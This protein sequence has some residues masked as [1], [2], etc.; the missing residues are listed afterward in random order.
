MPAA[1]TGLSG[2]ASRRC[3]LTRIPGVSGLQRLLATRRAPAIRKILALAAFFAIALG[4]TAVRADTDSLV[5]AIQ[6][7]SSENVTRKVF[8]PLADYLSKTAGMGCRLLISQNF[9]AYWDSVR[10]GTGYDLAL[11]AAHFTD[12]RIQKLGFK[13][14]V[15]EPGNVSYSLV[16]N[17]RTPIRDPDQLVAKRIATL[18]IPSIDATRLIAMFPNPSRQP[19]IVEVDSSKRGLDLVL[20]GRVAAAMLPTPFVRTAIARGDRLMVV[21][22]TEPIPGMA[23]SAAPSV[24]RVTRDAIRKA[25]LGANNTITGRKMLDAIGISH[26]DP[27]T[28]AVYRGQSRM[29]RSDWGY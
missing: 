16:V 25:L 21:A 9:F 5:L 2:T 7:G 8:Q 13:V 22:V 15:K 19:I 6:P 1:L 20:R 28:A 27:A 12:Y 17:K 4:S 11:D 14:L 10:N 18:G 23:L 3:A 24:D 26:F 29:L